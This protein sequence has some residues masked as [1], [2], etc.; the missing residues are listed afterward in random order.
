MG[1][2]RILQREL[3]G[4]VYQ[5]LPQAHCIFATGLLAKRRSSLQ[6]G[7]PR[8]KRYSSER[9]R[10]NMSSLALHVP[11]RFPKTHPCGEQA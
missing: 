5:R 4:A 2:V 11:I 7:F 8:R 10:M 3:R 9:V 6:A 1:L